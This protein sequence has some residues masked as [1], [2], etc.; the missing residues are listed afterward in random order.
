VDVTNSGNDV[1]E[2]EPMRQQ[3]RERTKQG[4]AEQLLDGGYVL[5]NLSSG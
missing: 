1:H 5:L 3:I 2:A 4:V